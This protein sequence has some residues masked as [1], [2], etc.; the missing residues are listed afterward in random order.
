MNRQLSLVLVA[1]CLAAGCATK[2]AAESD[3]LISKILHE[4]SAGLVCPSGDVRL[5]TID[6]DGE[7]H[8]QCVDHSEI[9]GR[10]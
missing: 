2:P 6:E 3:V 7:K 8:C 10:R 1:A 4:P 9:F 5:C